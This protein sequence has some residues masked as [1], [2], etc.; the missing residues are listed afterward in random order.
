MPDLPKCLAPVHQRPFLEL[1]ID[2]L[3]ERGVDRF[4]LSLGYMAEAVVEAISAFRIAHDIEYVIEKEQLGTGGAA[5]FALNETGEDEVL[6][7]NGDTWTDAPLTPMLNHLQ[8]ADGEL[9]R[10]AATH[11]PDRGRYGGLELSA[12]KVTGFSP[13]GLPG[14]GLIN[15]G[16]YRIHRNAFN[17]F[18]PGQAFSLEA[19][20]MP[21]LVEKGALTA[22]SLDGMFIDIGIP[23]DYR[24]FCDL[25]A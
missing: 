20:L 13:K 2:S 5:L 23:D 22:A 1:Q 4:V 14:A 25:N 19:D 16:L 21:Q 8:L 9:M 12:G 24:R 3:A 11:V 10:L 15:S 17:N 7:A 18:V 6:I